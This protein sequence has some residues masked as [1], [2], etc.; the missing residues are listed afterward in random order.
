MRDLVLITGASSGLGYNMALRLAERKY[1]LILVA[2]NYQKLEEFKQELQSKHSVEVYTF[3]SDLSNTDNAVS[4]Y[5]KITELGLDVTMLVNN[6]GVGHYGMF[7][8][9][10]VHEDLSVIELNISSVVVLTKLFAKEMCHKKRGKIMNVASL[11]S[12]LPL[13]YLSV[14]SATKSF[15]LAFTE[16][17]QAELENDNITV[18]AVCPGPIDTGFQSKEISNTY[19]YR[20]N[21]ASTPE[22]VAST[23]VKHLLNGKGTKIIG[24]Y[25]WFLVF[26]TRITPV[27]LMLRIRKILGSQHQ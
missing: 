27:A 7:T 14:Y 20:L 25:N 26:L 10:S 3:G 2:R 23:A 21:R 18:T 12:Y 11:L 1:D 16:C 15:I 4:L 9:A 8:N 13:P 6:A 22:S 5:N 19:A 17:L 24:P